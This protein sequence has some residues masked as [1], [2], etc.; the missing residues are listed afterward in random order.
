VSLRR[1]L[2]IIALLYVIEGFPMGVFMDLWPVYLRRQEM[3]LAGIGLIS[4]L[5]LAWSAKVLWSPLVDRFGEERRW[6]AGCLLVM[7]AS[8]LALPQVDASQLSP[9]LW[10]VLGIFCIASATQDVAIDAYT[11]GLVDRGEEGHA[12]SMR[13][14]AYRGGLIAAGGGLLL[15]ADATSYALTFLAAGALTAALALSALACP[16]VSPPYRE[17]GTFASL[18][19]W[20][21]RPDALAVAGFVLLYRLGDIAM[22]PMVKPFWVDRGFSDSEIGIVSGT[23]GVLAFVVGAVIG[24]AVVARIGIG[25]SLWVLGALALGS[26]LGYAGAAALPEIRSAVYAASIAE[27]FCAGLASNAFMSYLM[28]ICEKEHAAV[29]YA[30][31]TAI[32]ALPGFAAGAASGWITERIDYAAYFALTAVLALPAFAL[33]PRACRWISRETPAGD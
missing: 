21:G 2:S 25:R 22:G 14:S 12:N 33:L 19:R 23:I 18:R 11:I 30:L 24:G 13:I 26:N 15:L 4:G 7:T 20:S 16:R 6:I 1:K 3:S 5:R 31:L 10:A 8:L 17:E 32:Y 27:S 28:R 29:Q 9:L